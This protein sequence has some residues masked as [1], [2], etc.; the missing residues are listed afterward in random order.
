MQQKKIIFACDYNGI[1]LCDSLAKKIESL[2]LNV[3]NIGI[4]IGSSMDYVDITRL[5]VAELQNDLDAF[6]VIVCG[7]GQGVSIVANRSSQIR[8]AMC[9]TSEDAES[10]RSKLNANVLCL[11]SKYTTLE[12]ATSCLLSFINTSFKSEKHE[13]CVGKL[14]TNATDHSYTSANMIVRA[15][16]THEDHVLLTTTTETNTEFALG[17]YFLPG[18]HVDYKESAIDALRRELKEEMNLQANCV[19]FSGALECSW[20]RNGRIYHELNLVYSVDIDAL[21]LENPPEPIDSFHKFVWVP[22]SEITKYTIL[23]EKL[24]SLIQEA[25]ASPGVRSL[26]FSQMLDKKAA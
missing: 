18:G 1:E 5:L 26:F 4:K 6:G 13:K 23:P 8:A 7:S 3:K 22:I 11:G 10:V 21:T 20:N 14:T 9:R 16:I 19:E 24:V 25:T 17:L 12:E 15:I 2:G